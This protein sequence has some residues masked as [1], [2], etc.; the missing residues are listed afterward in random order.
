MATVIPHSASGDGL[1]LKGYN[2]PRNAQMMPNFYAV[3][4]EPEFFPD[5]YT[6]TLD[7]FLNKDGQAINTDKCLPFGTGKFGVN[8]FYQCDQSYTVVSIYIE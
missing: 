8:P 5:P 2:I 1:R 7:H 3:H 4:F 6:F